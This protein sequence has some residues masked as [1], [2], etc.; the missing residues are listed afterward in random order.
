MAHWVSARSFVG[1]TIAIPTGNPSLGCG[2]GVPE[3]ELV[4]AESAAA[5]LHP[6]SSKPRSRQNTNT[7]SGRDLEHIPADPVK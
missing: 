4:A 7:S 2:S 6:R 3:H 5:S 1:S